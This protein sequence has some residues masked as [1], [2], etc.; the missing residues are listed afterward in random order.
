MKSLNLI[1]TPPNFKA[2]T[3]FKNHNNTPSID[4]K[5]KHKYLNP[6]HIWG[7]LGTWCQEP[8]WRNGRICLLPNENPRIMIQNPHETWKQSIDTK[9]IYLTNLKSWPIRVYR[10]RVSGRRWFLSSK[11]KVL[12][13]RGQKPLW[14][15]L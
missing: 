3:K 12:K 1:I 6:P 11:R 2:L 7:S 10:T 9:D 15:Q 14:E 8:M 5:Q 4:T 13:G